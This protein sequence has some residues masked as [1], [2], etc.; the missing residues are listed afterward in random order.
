MAYERYVEAITASGP[1]PSLGAHA[2]TYGRLVGSW[3]GE[4]HNHMIP[5]SVRIGSI[6]IHLAWVLDGRAVQDTWITPARRDRAAANAAA[7]EWY[8]TTLRVFDPDTA[9]WRALW[10]D[11]V[12]R[13]QI[14]L[15]GR[16]HGD[17]VVQIG[18]R[19][20][21]PIRWTFSE[22]RESSFRWQGHV[23]HV[24]GVSWRLEVDIRARRIG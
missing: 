13:H 19:G 7:I 18:T 16:R 2:E 14:Q 4:I 8:G 5:G 15:E 24:D 17:D 21:W 6:E 12:S 22:I 20:G 3:T 9:S 11:P 23:L 1:H 10:W